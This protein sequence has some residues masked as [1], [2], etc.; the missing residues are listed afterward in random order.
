MLTQSVPFYK[1]NFNDFF[2][3][4]SPP[5]QCHGLLVS[6]YC[7]SYFNRRVL[8]NEGDKRRVTEMIPTRWQRQST[9]DGRRS[10]FFPDSCA[11]GRHFGPVINPTRSGAAFWNILP[12]E[13]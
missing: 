3:V 12:L 2:F 13:R 4:F 7:A 1:P 8:C 6:G 9:G 10:G 5:P 11:I